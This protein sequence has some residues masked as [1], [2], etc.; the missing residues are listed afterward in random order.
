MT[1]LILGKKKEN[2]QE[3]RILFNKVKGKKRKGITW[4]GFNNTFTKE[5]SYRKYDKTK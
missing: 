5:K 1:N 4:S 2:R 3:R